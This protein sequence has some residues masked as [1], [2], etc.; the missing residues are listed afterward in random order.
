[1]SKKQLFE[2]EKEQSDQQN[3]KVK[4]N[5]NKESEL[6][7]CGVEFKNPVEI[8]KSSNRLKGFGLNAI[9]RNSTWKTDLLFN[10]HDL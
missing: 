2:L 9:G 10:S 7:L 5:Y 3:D 1:M 8:T 6:T 4:G